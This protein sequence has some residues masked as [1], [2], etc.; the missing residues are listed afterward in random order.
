MICSISSSHCFANFFFATAAALALARF[1]GIFDLTLSAT[2]GGAEVFLTGF[3]TGGLLVSD[4]ALGVPLYG[5]TFF[6]AGGFLFFLGLASLLVARKMVRQMRRAE[7]AARRQGMRIG[8]RARWI[9]WGGGEGSRVW[10]TQLSH[11][12]A[13][14]QTFLEF[15]RDTKFCREY[16]PWTS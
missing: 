11:R 13:L 4:L 15:G 2:V 10:Q 5:F 9:G 1:G 14:L 3:V 6:T 12:L 8:A 16:L 7:M